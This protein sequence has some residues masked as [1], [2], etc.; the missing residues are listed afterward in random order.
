MDHFKTL[1][2]V[3][4]LRHTIFNQQSYISIYVFVFMYI[5]CIYVL[6]HISASKNPMLVLYSIQHSVCMY[7]VHHHGCNFFLCFISIYIVFS[8][9][10]IFA[11]KFYAHINT[12][13]HTQHRQI[14]VSL[15]YSSLFHLSMAV[16][17]YPIKWLHKIGPRINKMSIFITQTDMNSFDGILSTMYCN[18]CYIHIYIYDTVLSK[19][20]I[21]LAKTK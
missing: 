10:P 4:N 1:E 16:S 17:L 20:W 21:K 3:L 2:L 6:Y 7:S 8:Q 15:F 14:L 9:N 5:F 13:T 19:R 12:H 18:D 11:R